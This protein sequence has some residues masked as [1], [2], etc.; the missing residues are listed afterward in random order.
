MAVPLRLSRQVLSLA[1]GAALFVGCGADH[2]EGG[3]RRSELPSSQAGTP[4]VGLSGMSSN[5]GSATS[6]QGSAGEANSADTSE[7]AGTSNLAG[8]YP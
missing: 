6:E 4:N 8:A 1:F 7:I 3:G 5:G 2:Y